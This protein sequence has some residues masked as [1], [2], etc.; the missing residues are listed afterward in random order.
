M[1]EKL[2]YRPHV[3]SGLRLSVSCG[4]EFDSRTFRRPDW[5]NNHRP[6]EADDPVINR[7]TAPVG[8]WADCREG[9]PI[10]E[11]SGLPFETSLDLSTN[12]PA[13]V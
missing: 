9:A 10:M 12:R 2:A 3:L 7:M 8:S 6:V 1:D 5:L 13:H 11:W 4:F